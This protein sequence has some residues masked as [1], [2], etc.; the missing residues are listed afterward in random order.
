MESYNTANNYDEQAR[1]AFY[2]HFEGQ[3]TVESIATHVQ[4]NRQF[5]IAAITIENGCHRMAS[6]AV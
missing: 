2:V 4:G 6:N 1:D 3:K 5:K